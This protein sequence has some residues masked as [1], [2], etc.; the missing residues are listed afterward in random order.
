MTVNG[1]AVE[2]SVEPRTQLAEFLRQE[3]QLTG[4][5]LACEHGVCG[6]CTVLI[7]GKPARS[8]I[9]YAV[10]CEGAEVTTVEG[11]RD[12]E[13]MG[14]LRKAF[15]KH[16]GLQCGF[17][18]PGM[19]T[20]ARDIVV[21][22]P[23]ADEGR[24]RRELA[25]NLCRCTGYM[26]IVAAISEVIAGRRE[27]G[28]AAPEAPTASPQ[29][30]SFE[31]TDTGRQ[32]EQ[33]RAG[34]ESEDGW[35]SVTERFDVPY[36]PDV[37]WELLS[38]A[39]RVAPCIPGAAIEGREGNHIRGRLR[40]RFGPISATFAGEGE[41]DNDPERMRGRVSGSA[42]DGKGSRV[43]GE[44]SYALEGKGGEAT[45]IEAVLRF[46]L[47]GSLAQFTRIGLANDFVRQLAQEFS[48]NLSR[49][50]SG[51]SAKQGELGAFGLFFSAL[52]RWLRRLLGRDDEA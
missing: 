23:D 4:T 37:V 45:A 26:G 29:L 8:C 27:G 41:I 6:A 19:L 31:A 38:D 13:V 21:R 22:L 34:P 46:R 14:A 36:P 39:E 7:D 11:F 30:E 18:T 35:I 32:G 3:L 10:A 20:T 5:H 24:I 43:K 42:A 25:G 47:A 33:A 49:V 48:G 16:H 17:C 51:K 1:D 52:R 9:T 15:A 40:V 12:D 28:A 44:F 2:A 50:L